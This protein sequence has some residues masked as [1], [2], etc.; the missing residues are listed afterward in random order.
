MAY[1]ENFGFESIDDK[2]DLVRFIQVCDEQYV[3]EVNKLNDA[4]RNIKTNRR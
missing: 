2:I 1:A 4:N 3:L